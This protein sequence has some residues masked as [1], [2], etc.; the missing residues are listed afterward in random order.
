[1][2]ITTPSNYKVTLKD[3]LTFGEKRTL[4]R[5]IVEGT[6]VD[7]DSKQAPK[8]QGTQLYAYQDKAFEILVQKIEIEDKSYDSS[9][10][11]LYEM[12]MSWREEDGKAVFD[13][14]LEMISPKETEKK[15]SS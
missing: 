11:N 15:S 4:E 1:M 6:V 8:I 9:N 2:I 5:T 13:K 10:Q 14:I 7:T 3:F 12:V